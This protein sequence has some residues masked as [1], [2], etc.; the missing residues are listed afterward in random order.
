[1]EIK[2][3]DYKSPDLDSCGNTVIAEIHYNGMRIPLCEDCLNSLRESLKS[4]DETIFCYKCADFIMSNDGWNYG[5][6]CLRSIEDR[7][8]FDPKN[9]GYVEYTYCMGSCEHAVKKDSIYAVSLYENENAIYKINIKASNERD[10]VFL[11]KQFVARNGYFPYMSEDQI[12]KSLFVA[13]VVES[14]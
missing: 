3:P 1:M 5:G 4:Y 2:A 12:M 6:T 14:K 9:A 8:S 11:A 7:E 13:D 10:A